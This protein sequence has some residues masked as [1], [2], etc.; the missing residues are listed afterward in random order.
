MVRRGRGGRRR[1]R[2]GPRKERGGEGAGGL[3]N[4][5][6]P[7]MMAVVTLHRAHPRTALAALAA[8]V[9]TA[10]LL[11]AGPATAGTVTVAAGDTLSGIAARNGVSVGAL[12]RAN[13]ISDPN[14]VT[15]GRHLVI[16]SGGT[17]SGGGGGGGSYR[18]RA[19]DS[20][21]A[22]AAR[23]GVSVSALVAANGITNPNL[24]VAGRLLTIPSGGGA[25]SGGASAGGSSSTYRVRS[26]DTLSG[27]AARYGTSTSALAARNGIPAPYLISIGRTLTVPAAAQGG[28]NPTSSAEVRD[29]IARHAARYGVDQYLVRAIAWQESGWNQTKRSHVG[30]IG[31]MQLMPVTAR[32]LGRDVV[33]RHLDPHVLSDNIEGGV[34]YIAWLSRHAGGTRRV[35]AAYYQGLASL[36]ARGPYDDTIAYVRSVLALRGRV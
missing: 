19:G 22:I 21:G 3:E 8:A 25:S 17:A 29:L 13:G 27:I 12:V 26:G 7:P 5:V 16:P 4:R 30:A 15:A 33:G 6:K 2:A 35:I 9:V 10:L 23:N 1:G 34:A 36:R 28:G 24:V 18:V 11:A 20:L 31:V 14:H 32:W